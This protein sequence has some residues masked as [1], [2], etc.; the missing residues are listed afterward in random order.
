MLCL[1]LAVASPGFEVL[2]VCRAGNLSVQEMLKTRR[3]LSIVALRTCRGSK[4]N[5]KTHGSREAP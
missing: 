3:F 2:G 1:G 5:V 4:N